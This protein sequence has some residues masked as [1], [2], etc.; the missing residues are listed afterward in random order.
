MWLLL[1][2]NR[3]LIHTIVSAAIETMEASYRRGKRT[4]IIQETIY[5]KTA[6]CTYYKRKKFNSWPLFLF[7][8]KSL[9]MRLWCSST[10][11][12]LQRFRAA[13]FDSDWSWSS[14]YLNGAVMDHVCWPH[15]A[16]LTY[17]RVD[18][19]PTATV[20]I[21]ITNQPVSQKYELLTGTELNKTTENMSLL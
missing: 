20:C 9:R 10:E 2:S 3:K 18:W 16:K 1:G 4:L 12:S 6:K 8:L 15:T 14:L 19:T 17:W 7:L 21:V 13:W 5:K 11:N